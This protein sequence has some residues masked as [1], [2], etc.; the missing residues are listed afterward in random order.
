MQRGR[1]VGTFDS[2]VLF[3]LLILALFLFYDTRNR[4]VA[5]RCFSLADVVF[6]EPTRSSSNVRAASRRFPKEE[7]PFATKEA[8]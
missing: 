8:P 5:T 7:S 4:K 6:L 3:S 2:F 1:L